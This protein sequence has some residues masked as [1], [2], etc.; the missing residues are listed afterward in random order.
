MKK[1]CAWCHPGIDHDPIS[2]E[3]YS[4][5]ICAEHAAEMKRQIELLRRNREQVNRECQQIMREANK[6]N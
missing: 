6:L 1:I 5:G 4:H 3:V 2:G